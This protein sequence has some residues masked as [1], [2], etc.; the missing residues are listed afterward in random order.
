MVCLTVKT[1]GFERYPSKAPVSVSLIL[2]K[3]REKE[4]NHDLVLYRTQWHTED[5]AKHVGFFCKNN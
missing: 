1:Q 5:P 3:E 4:K 2:S